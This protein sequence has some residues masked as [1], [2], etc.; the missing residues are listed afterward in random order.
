MFDRWILVHA[1]V[2]SSRAT[3]SSRSNSPQGARFRCLLFEKP[4][5]RNTH[6]KHGRASKDAKKGVWRFPPCGI[7]IDEPGPMV[8]TVTWTDP[9]PL[10]SRVSVEGETVHVG[11]EGDTLHVIEVNFRPAGPPVKFI[12]KVPA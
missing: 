6:P 7:A 12:V 4:M 5:P 11:P 8:L 10:A 9:F 3:V 1:P 2:E